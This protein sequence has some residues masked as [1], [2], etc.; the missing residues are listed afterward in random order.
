M[1]NTKL[2]V[3]LVVV[4]LVAAYFLFDIGQYL[5][6]EFLQAKRKMLVAH[7]TENPVS[8]IATFFLLYVVA[9]V[10]SI[11][12]ISL[13]SIGAGAIFGSFTGFILV[14]FAATIG[15]TVAFL[16]SRYLFKNVIENKFSSQVKSINAGIEKEGAFYLFTMRLIPLIPFFLINLVMGLTNM[17]T[18]VFY[19]VSQIGMIPT[20][21]IFTYSGNQ[22]AKIETMK[23]ILSPGLLLAF[24]LLG[25]FPFAAKQLIKFYKHRQKG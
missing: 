1:K 15:A 22:L 18:S 23:D 2:L 20:S 5:S 7:A 10:I 19:I 14:S 17:K 13:L 4:A 21:A 16:L 6:L 8:S 12:G 3:A 11:P 9:A 24:A 25:I